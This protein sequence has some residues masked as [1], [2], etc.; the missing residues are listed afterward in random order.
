MCLTV[1]F[2]LPFSYLF[3]TLY[4]WIIYRKEEI[5]LVK[6]VPNKK[7][8]GTVAGNQTV[9]VFLRLGTFLPLPSCH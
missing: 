7:G 8:L 5:S 6:A 3:P 9:F 2:L 1:A 4:H